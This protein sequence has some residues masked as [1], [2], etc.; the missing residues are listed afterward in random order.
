M[1][2]VI[3]SCNYYW[4]LACVCV[5]AQSTDRPNRTQSVYKRTYL[6]YLISFYRSFDIWNLQS[7]PLVPTDIHRRQ[8]LKQRNS[9]NAFGCHA[10]RINSKTS[11]IIYKLCEMCSAVRIY[12]LF[13][14]VAMHF[15]YSGRMW[16]M[17]INRFIK[18]L[19]AIANS[20]HRICW[21]SLENWI[22]AGSV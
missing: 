20:R 17:K 11:H 9:M 8:P 6:E 21:M 12:I 18:L 14:I 16:G 15:N 19:F 2:A 1:D 22:S 4:F 5:C 10:H 13:L 7:V 3:R